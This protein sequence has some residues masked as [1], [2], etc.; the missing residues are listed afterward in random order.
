ML[1]DDDGALVTVPPRQAHRG[2]L[3]RTVDLA[4][5]LNALADDA[6]T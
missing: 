3:R 4:Y 1:A 5:G 6:E 2:N